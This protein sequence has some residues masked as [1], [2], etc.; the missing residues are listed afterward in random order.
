MHTQRWILVGM[1]CERFTRRT[2]GATPAALVIVVAL[3]GAWS[4]QSW[5]R[6]QTA[7]PAQL[8][9]LHV[10]APASAGQLTWVVEATQREVRIG[11]VVAR[12][13]D[14]STGANLRSPARGAVRAVL[15]RSG[16]A[17]Q[18][19]DP[20]VIVGPPEGATCP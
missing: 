16:E 14:T 1:A 6:R 13:G 15:K 10:V 2:L 11:D 3:G 17:V 19:G 5:L 7:T 4:L 9:C 12:V 20:I 18:A 8:S